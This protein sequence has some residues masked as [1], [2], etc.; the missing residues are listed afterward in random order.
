MKNTYQ[1]H[2]FNSTPLVN[3]LSNLRRTNGE[4]TDRTQYSFFL[5]WWEEEQ[6]MTSPSRW[7]SIFL[8][9][10]FTTS[11]DR[12]KMQMLIGPKPNRIHSYWRTRKFGGTRIRSQDLTSRSW[13]LKNISHIIIIQFTPRIRRWWRW[14]WYRSINWIGACG[15]WHHTST[16]TRRADGQ[17][18][19]RWG[20]VYLI[21]Q[22]EPHCK[23]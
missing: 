12:P 10:L 15:S 8:L 7:D 4:Y 21:R 16:A 2:S 5:G 18:R 3:S 19:R 20:A 14:Y 17:S 6:K 11:P 9:V 23:R 22:W 13:P 1:F